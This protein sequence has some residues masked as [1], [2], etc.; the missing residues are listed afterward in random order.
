MITQIKISNFK[1]IADSGLLPLRQFMVLIG[2]NGS[3]KSSIIEALDWLGL[4]LSQDAEAATEGFQ[5]MSD[6]I[7]FWTEDNDRRAEITIEFDPRDV[8]IGDKIIYTVHIGSEPDG[9]PFIAYENLSI[10]GR[11]SDKTIIRTDPSTKVRVIEA[12]T[13]ASEEISGVEQSIQ[14]TERR[15]IDPRLRASLSGFRSTLAN[16]GSDSISV[17]D[18]SRLA[19]SLVDSRRSLGGYRLRDYLERAVFLR[20]NPRMIAN[21]SPSKIR[22]T[23]RLLDTQGRK[24]ATL[25]S[26]LDADK[27]EI[28]VGKLTSIIPT[29]N[30]MTAHEPTGP[31]DQR[32]FMLFEDDGS[33]SANIPAWVLSEGTRRMTAILAVLLHDEPPPLICIEEVENGFDPWTL[34]FLLEELRGALVR[35]TQVILTTHSPYF[36]DMLDQ[37]NIILCDR[38]SHRVEF[39]TGDKLPSD[40]EIQLHMGL[41]SRYKN[42][43]LYPNDEEDEWV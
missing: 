6:I 25:L 14:R 43:D 3:G 30:A 1:V 10:S 38:K 37:N 7:R 32:Y 27:L 24:L 13:D 21:F 4:A 20:L 39:Y 23:P 28:L 2:R 42:Q 41:G 5:R 33:A 36:L 16:I 31:S 8:S 40:E 29:A 18:P 9:T 11:D 22:R 34:R 19:L 17:N 15:E 26:E 12:G 35:N